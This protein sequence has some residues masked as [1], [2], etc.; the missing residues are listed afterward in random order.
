MDLAACLKGIKTAVRK[1]VGR[2]PREAIATLLVEKTAEAVKNI[3]PK[4][5]R[6]HLVGSRLRHRYAR[7]LDF[8]AVV[9]SLRDMPGRNVTLKIGPLGVNLFA[10]LPEEVEPTILE[11]GLG[12]DIIRWKRKAL[13]LGFVLNRF[14]LWRKG[15]RV[16]NRMAEISAILGM[17]LKPH[18]VW[19]LKHPY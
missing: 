11:Y 9:S 8:V 1:K 12:L 2:P 5:K 3:F 16:S 7:D 18:L 6:L 17:P 14:G 10:A 13:S 15:V 19:S 4:V